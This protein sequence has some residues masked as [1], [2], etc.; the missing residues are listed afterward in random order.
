MPVSE[1]S[2]A[3][4]NGTKMKGV[5]GT[6]QSGMEEQENGKVNTRREK[7]GWDKKKLYEVMLFD[8]IPETQRPNEASHAILE[9]ELCK[10][11][12]V[13][14]ENN[15]IVRNQAL[16]H[17]IADLANSNDTDDI[18]DYDFV[19]S[20]LRNGAD[21]NCKDTTGQTIFHEVARSWNSDVAI[22]LVKN[23]ICFF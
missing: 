20:L 9:G 13:D 2:T 4:L 17:Y 7:D 23:G 3:L 10:L 15:Q 12:V 11:D 16:I 1:D 5:D 18:F 6:E 21:I 14:G 19:E 22:F 8:E